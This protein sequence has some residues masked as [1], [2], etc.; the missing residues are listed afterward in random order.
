MFVSRRSF[1]AGASAAAV[2]CVGGRG[3]WA[4][5]S[6]AQDA[7][8][9]PEL[10]YAYDALEPHIDTLTMNVHHTRHHGAFVANLNRLAGQHA[11]LREM[12]PQQLLADD[13]A[14]VP[15]TIRTAVRNN[16][17]GHLNHTNYW[18]ILNPADRHAEPSGPLLAAIERDLGGWEKAKAELTA[19]GMG[20]FGSG[21]A[22]LLW[23]DGK[24][25]I[26]STPNQDSPWMRGFT[27]LMGIDVWEHA[28]YLKHLNRRA[29][30]LEAFWQVA[31]WR[32]VGEKFAAAEK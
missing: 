9:L 8:V 3:V 10:G 30:Y 22:W 7:F 5:T 2:A 20:R 12:T 25:S 32:V 17:G 29:D 31:N 19:S 4:G 15:E 26:Q 21:W 1:L 27:P 28:Y 24:L 11:M 16:L 18:E 14:A 13:C 6:L 23:K